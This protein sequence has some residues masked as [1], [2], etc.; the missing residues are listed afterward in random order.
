MRRAEIW[1]ICEGCNEPFHP[2]YNRLDAKTCSTKCMGLVKRNKVKFNC[3]YCG[4]EGEC[5]PS[6]LKHKKVYCSSEHMYK[7]QSIDRQGEGSPWVYKRGWFLNSKGYKEIKVNGKYTPEHIVI[8]EQMIGRKLN[9]DEVVHH[10]NE[11]K[12]DN[13]ERNLQVMTR[14]EHIKLHNELNRQRGWFLGRPTKPL[15]TYPEFEQWEK[16]RR[17]E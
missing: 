4:I 3:A 12:T 5:I 15:E 6:R 8:A 7:Q 17:G 13:D 14:S 1:N 11:I 2:W 10:K 16:N 9:P